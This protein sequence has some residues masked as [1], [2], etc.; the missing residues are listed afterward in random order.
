[1]GI[2]LCSEGKISKCWN[3]RGLLLHV[4]KMLGYA[5]SQ[6]CTQCVPKDSH[7]I[8]WNL[9]E[10]QKETGHQKAKSHCLQVFLTKSCIAWKD[11]D[12]CVF[13]SI[14]L[15]I[16]LMFTS[17]GV[18]FAFP[19]ASV[20]CWHQEWVSLTAKRSTLM[21]SEVA[22]KVWFCG[23]K[24]FQKCALPEKM[25]VCAWNV[26]GC[27][28]PH[29]HEPRK[30]QSHPLPPLM[31]RHPTG[32]IDI[33]VA[34]THQATCHPHSRSFVLVTSHRTLDEIN[35][36]MG[37]KRTEAE[38]TK[39]RLFGWILLKCILWLLASRVVNKVSWCSAETNPN[40]YFANFSLT[41]PPEDSLFCFCFA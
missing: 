3:F 1:M 2:K 33:S 40:C 24:L 18:L 11:A 5:L 7:F 15:Q 6:K 10:L 17:F 28:N 36:R 13:R 29:R 25:H 19:E 37:W 21:N 30:G 8:E 38:G 26:I 23:S 9:Q 31:C 32:P 22:A 41:P 12:W 39:W 4:W 16:R 14:A 34:S 27:P 20:W 35:S